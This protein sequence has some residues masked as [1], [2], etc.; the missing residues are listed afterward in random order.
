MNKK[1]QTKTHTTKYIS[2]FCKKLTGYRRYYIY[3]R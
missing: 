1:R 3:L 2:Y